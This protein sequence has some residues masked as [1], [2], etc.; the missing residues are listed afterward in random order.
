L[1]SIL[2]HWKRVLA[3]TPFVTSAERITGSRDED[4]IARLG[5]GSPL[6]IPRVHGTVQWIRVTDSSPELRATGSLK[7]EGPVHFGNA[8]HNPW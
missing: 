6:L 3:K 1:Y 8:S 7:R 2:R 5:G 4:S